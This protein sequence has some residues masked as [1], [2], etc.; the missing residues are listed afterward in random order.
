MERAAIITAIYERGV[1]VP[2]QDLGLQER[3]TVRLQVVPPGVCITAATARRK[4]NRFVL[5]EISYL[6]GGERPTLIETDR[7]I[8]RVPVVLTY[9]T[10]GVVGRVGFIDVDARSGEL[11]LTPE[12]VEEI[13]HNA[14]ALAAR[15]SSEATS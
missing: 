6:M 5:D 9:P 1:L 14:R 2:L 13:T 15:L 3:Q 10:H 12:T 7:L 4:V 11:L 8:W